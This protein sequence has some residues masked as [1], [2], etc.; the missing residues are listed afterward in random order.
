MAS[1]RAPAIRAPKLPKTMKA[2]AIDRF[3]PPSVLTLHELPVPEIDDNEVLIALHTAGVGSW[4]AKIRDGT[5]AEEKT[6]FP[7]VL[8]TD[9]AGQVVARGSR[10]R[11]VAVGAKVWSYAYDNPKGGFYAEYVAV[12]AE[13]VAAIP[14]LFDLRKAGASAVTGLTAVQGIDDHLKLERGQTILIFGASGAVGILAVQLAKCRKACVLA[15]ASTEDAK[16]LLLELGAD[17]VFDARRADPSA[18]LEALTPDGLDAA[19]VL[20]SNDKLEE[21]LDRVR[22]RGRIAHPTASSRHRGSGRM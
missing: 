10:V 9:G 8:G 11:R 5:W 17:A 22:R 14:R 12:D 21:C 6:R 3:G 13:H 19:L 18:V 2:A 20:A 7:L 4:D 15:T 1:R 16:K